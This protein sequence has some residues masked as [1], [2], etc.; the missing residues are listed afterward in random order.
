[1]TEQATPDP[2]QPPQAGTT[3]AHAHILY[4]HHIHRK[5]NCEND[6]NLEHSFY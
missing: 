2:P 3:E 1:M 6:H 4:T 5:T